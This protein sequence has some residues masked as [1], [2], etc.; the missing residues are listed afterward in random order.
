MSKFVVAVLKAPGINYLYTKYFS[1]AEHRFSK[2]NREHAELNLRVDKAS[3]DKVLLLWDSKAAL[4]IG[5]HMNTNGFNFTGIGC[6]YPEEKDF[7]VPVSSRFYQNTPKG[8]I[9]AEEV[10]IIKKMILI[11]D[12]DLKKNFN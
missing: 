5:C 2:K 7:S 4:T 9:I 10:E 12:E 8:K 1:P 3:N 11:Y 6:Y